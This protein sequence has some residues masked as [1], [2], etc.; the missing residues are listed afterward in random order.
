MIRI[1]AGSAKGKRLKT[2]KGPAVR[3]TSDKVRGAI[4]NILGESIIGASVLDLF[5]GSGALGIE[6]L[7]R[8]AK[9]GVFVDNGIRC[10]SIIKENLSDCGF[11]G[12]VIRGDVYK[13][14]KR[15]EKGSFDIVFADPPYG[16]DL[17]RNLLLELDKSGIL[18]NSCF[19]IIEHS[20]REY[21]EESPN[22]HKLREKRYGDTRV[23]VYRSKSAL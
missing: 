20:K 13:V 4:F 12:K 9:E 7:S 11:L 21:I 3:P 23:S 19:V 5:S 15:L 6:A 1:I 2:L 16:R 18:K 14:I 10:I 22:W 17:A 8:G